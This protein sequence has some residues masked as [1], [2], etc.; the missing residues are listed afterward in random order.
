MALI[1]TFES[2]GPGRRFVATIP[3]G[4]GWPE[5]VEACVAGLRAC[6]FVIQRGE[7]EEHF[8]HEALEIAR[9]EDPDGPP[10]F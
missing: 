2:I 1:I 6:G 9:A 4:E 10:D 8:V 5:A 7:A 3:S